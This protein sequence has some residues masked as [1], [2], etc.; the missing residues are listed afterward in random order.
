MQRTFATLST[1]EL[2]AYEDV[3][4]KYRSPWPDMMVYSYLTHNAA[5]V[6]HTRPQANTSLYSVSF[7]WPN[8]DVRQ[9]LLSDIVFFVF[10]P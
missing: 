7:L 5:D 10:I 2:R 4:I 1:H 6:D 3:K 8:V 9:S